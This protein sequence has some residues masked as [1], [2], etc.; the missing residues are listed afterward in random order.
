M[1]VFRI[2][3][4]HRPSENSSELYIVAIIAIITKHKNNDTNSGNNNDKDKLT[5]VMVVVGMTV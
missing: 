1:Y 3:L 5:A 4:T 2:R